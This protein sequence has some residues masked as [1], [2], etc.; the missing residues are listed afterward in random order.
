M[1]LRVPHPELVLPRMLLE[2]RRVHG[3]NL[4]QSLEDRLDGDRA[5]R[6]PRLQAVRVAL[7]QRECSLQRAI[8]GGNDRCLVRPVLIEQALVPEQRVKQLVTKGTE[9]AEHHEQVIAR[10]DR[11]RVKLQTTQVAN[12]LVNRVGGDGPLRRAAQALTRNCQL[13]RTVHPHRAARVGYPQTS[14]A[15]STMRR[16]LATSSS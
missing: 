3:V 11:R 8:L 7:R 16:S 10:D 15:V 13:S 4:S 9:A 1:L 14:A 5:F 12:E 2:V 6:N